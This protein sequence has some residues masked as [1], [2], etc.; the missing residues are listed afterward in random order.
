MFKY[1]FAYQFSRLDINEIS[2]D[3]FLELPSLKLRKGVRFD[4]SK[5]TKNHSEMCSQS[6][7]L[8]SEGA[9]EK[10]RRLYKENKSLVNL[11]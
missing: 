3:K 5:V 8:S 6:S 2:A 7:S 9:L 10:L 11:H 1:D 4:E